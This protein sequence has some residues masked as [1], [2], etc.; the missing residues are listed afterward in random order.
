MTAAQVGG[1][2]I[3]ILGLGISACEARP[4]PS[5]EGTLGRTASAIV[6]G[7]D[8]SADLPTANVVVE[9]RD[10]DKECSGTLISPLIVLTAG[11]CIDGDAS[12]GF[13]GAFGS[14]PPVNAGAPRS[15]LVPASDLAPTHSVTRLGHQVGNNELADD[16]AL[17][18]LDEAALQT[19]LEDVS[20]PSPGSSP[21][22]VP[23]ESVVWNTLLEIRSERPSFDV[24]R[25][26]VDGA[27][28]SFLDVIGV[29]GFGTF[30]E[31]RQVAFFGE[32]SLVRVNGTWRQDQ[33][34][35][36]EPTVNVHEI[37]GD[38]GG[39]LFTVRAGR[40]T[41][42]P[43]G[44]QSGNFL[45]ASD[46]RIN[47]WADLTRP[48]I[49]QWIRDT[50]RDESR[51]A[52]WLAR[53]GKSD[54]WF[55]EVDYTGACDTLRDPDC[56]HWFSWHD[57]CP[58]RYNPGQRDTDDDGYGDACDNCV[59][60]QNPG[61]ENCNALSE[62]VNHPNI[63]P[64]GDACDPV[65]CPLSTVGA[66]RTVKTCQPQPLGPNGEDQGLACQS[67]VVRDDLASAPIGSHG[68]D[69][70]VTIVP[71]VDTSARFCQQHTAPPA[72]DCRA[73]ESIQDLQL[74]FPDEAHNPA[75][76]WHRVTFGKI[77]A[78]AV[79]PRGASLR[80]DYGQT[81]ATDRWSFAKDYAF[82]L[83]NPG[84]PLI[85]LPDDPASCESSGS[86]SGTCLN[87]VF[88][89]HADT[90]VGRDAHGD[91]LANYHFD[92]RPDP[93]K[94]FCEV[95][96]TIAGATRALTIERDPTAHS[97][98]ILWPWRGVER[99][100]DVQAQRETQLV[101]A[102]RLGVVGAL[103][104]DGAVIA[105]S[106]DGTSPCRGTDIGSLTAHA[107]AHGT[108]ASAVEPNGRISGLPS[109][110]LA[111]ALSAD[112]TRMTEAIVDSRAGVVAASS[113]DGGLGSLFEASAADGP[114][115]PPR[116]G[117][118]SL[119]S[120]RAGGAFVIGGADADGVIQRDVWFLPF[121]GSWN[122]IPLGDVR[123]GRVLA[124]TY[125]FGD[126]HLWLVDELDELANPTSHI[127]RARILR[128]DPAGGGTKIMSL[129]SRR[130]APFTAFLSVDR[131]GAALLALAGEARFTILRLRSK[132][133]GG[134][135]VGR[136]RTERGKLVR[137]PIVDDS[138]YS[139]VVAAPDGG[140]RVRRREALRP[141]DCDDDDEDEDD[142]RPRLAKA[143]ECDGRLL[144][145]LF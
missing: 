95:R 57:N 79:P 130:P 16:V 56:D 59:G 33:G 27:V 51:T 50:A 139:F 10:G 104:H 32:A 86:L 134:L 68:A 144:E 30:Q 69:G 116:A 123:L 3:A 133:N 128:V 18:F 117:Y 131:D 77:S 85:P 13:R 99:S 81:L 44:V 60:V 93:F 87:G 64:V 137:A 22:P 14:K 41:R 8:D 78:R 63:P 28:Y 94:L 53:H 111:V 132:S 84:N 1:R 24:P 92:W 7:Q 54:L 75:R 66:A 140:L 49:A 125:A 37:G 112:G 31:I 67:R 20:R 15:G 42:D 142:T 73:F 48:A 70:G 29:A 43:F 119:F 100:F 25:S 96:S 145:K 91:Q 121:G 39:P 36:N 106:D 114:L 52:G 108:W 65:P 102:S 74:T 141:V 6:G 2:L 127:S 34:R 97:G 110:I 103:L 98:E 26:T 38:S 61:Q 58:S 45:D 80:W 89:L 62:G 72:V 9:L 11:H 82:W 40:K 19:N 101:V 12:S 46:N 143:A 109:E 17:V 55:G 113:L 120:R 23:L 135:V 107:V 4:T 105:L 122:P 5:S 35:D 83:A 126:D 71:N 47:V 129:A 90:P 76:P 115:P 88:W 136:V 118:A 21:G 124:A 138:G